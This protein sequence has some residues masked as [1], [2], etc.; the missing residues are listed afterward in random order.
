MDSIEALAQEWR[1]EA[2]RIRTR[3]ADEHG[4]RLCEA[5]AAELEERVRTHQHQALPLSVAADES[6]YSVSQLRRMISAGQ[7][8]DVGDGRE[9]R[10]RRGELPRKAGRP[11][12]EAVDV[13]KMP[14][15]RSGGDVS[16]RARAAAS[17]A[18]AGG[19]RRT[20]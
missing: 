9:P 7:L 6:R 14:R 5:H 18:A 16:A 15:A 8:E 1:D 12:A 2:Q 17:R 19:I 20:G 13:V 3:Y 10:V 4:A 11:E